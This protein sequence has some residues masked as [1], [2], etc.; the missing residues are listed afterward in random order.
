MIGIGHGSADHGAV[1]KHKATQTLKIV[2][3]GPFQFD[4][5]LQDSQTYKVAVV[6]DPP[7]QSCS[8][9]YGTDTGSALKDLGRNGHQKSVVIR[10][11]KQQQS[12][13]TGEMEKRK[14]QCVKCNGGGY[15]PFDA[16]CSGRSIGCS[17]DHG[18]NG[19]CYGRQALTGQTG[20]C[21]CDTGAFSEPERYALKGGVRG[22]LVGQWLELGCSTSHGLDRKSKTSNEQVPG[23]FPTVH[24]VNVRGMGRQALTHFV[25]P[26]KMAD[27]Q[28]YSECYYSAV[29]RA[30]PLSA[31]RQSCPPTAS[32]PNA[33]IH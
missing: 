4:Y 8:F 7:G 21:T 20:R 22:L 11:V 10:C 19:G 16:Y 9:D 27:G 32:A 6:K 33:A 31:R 23:G 14:C 28:A 17:V 3:G 18:E 2:T 29:A 13:A 30:L 26:Y 25:C 1:G 5:K 24:S 12:W 15:S